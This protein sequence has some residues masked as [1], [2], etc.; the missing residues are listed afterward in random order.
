[1]KELSERARVVLERY[2]VAQRGADSEHAVLF[3]AVLERARTGDLPRFE[4]NSA[5]PTMPAPHWLRRFWSSAF[6]KL[7]VV[8]ALLGVSAVGIYSHTP[9]AARVGQARDAAASA[10]TIAS[11]VA[12]A[13]DRAAA[14]NGVG[15]S[16]PSVPT[17][18]APSSSEAPG[19][20]AK[21]N[22][23]ATP[24]DQATLDEEIRLLDTA[25]VAMRA[26]DST[27]ALQVLA[28]HAS[29]FPNGQMA[30]ARNIMRMK[31]LVQAGQTEQACAEAQRFLVSYPKSPFVGRV[32]AIC[33]KLGDHE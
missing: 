13:S 12:S 32:K 9:S 10:S 8:A 4:V 18:E 11:P 26:G 16:V 14:D 24:V 28:E 19:K 5:P 2:K 33:P 29:R 31:A 1:M 21:S 17:A 3:E 15:P 30:S 6:V 7:G 23:R 22:R 25:Q 27:R 20:A